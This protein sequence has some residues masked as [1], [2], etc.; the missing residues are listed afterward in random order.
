[1]HGR[2]MCQH[3]ANGCKIWIEHLGLNIGLGQWIILQKTFQE[4]GAING[5]FKSAIHRRGFRR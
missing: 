1:M 3:L 2:Y 5:E 4:F